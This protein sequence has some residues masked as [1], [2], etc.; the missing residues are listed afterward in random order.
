LEIGKGLKSVAVLVVIPS[1]GIFS[2]FFFATK[3]KLCTQAREPF[4]HGWYFKLD[5]APAYWVENVSLWIDEEFHP[6]KIGR[7]CPLPSNL[8][9]KTVGHQINWFRNNK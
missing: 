8:G 7:D 1:L 6:C 2:H 9:H 5:G 4:G 3:E